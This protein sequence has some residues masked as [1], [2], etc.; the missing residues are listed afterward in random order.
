MNSALAGACVGCGS[1]VVD[2]WCV[3]GC[4]VPDLCGG[5]PDGD[6]VYI[7]AG[8]ARGG[9]GGGLLEH[10]ELWDWIFLSFVI[11]IF[12]GGYPGIL[13]CLYTCDDE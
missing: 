8:C 4:R 12:L 9:G 10:Y 6:W 3:C 11:E 2:A 7:E 5:L 13:Q 1:P